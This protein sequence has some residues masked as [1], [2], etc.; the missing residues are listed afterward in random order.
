MQDLIKQE[1]FEIEVLDRLKSGRFLDK[2]VFTGGTMLRLCYGLN[3]YSVDLDFWIVKE[4][5]MSK[6]Y[7]DLIKYMTEFYTIKDSMNKFYTIVIEMRKPD[8]ARSLKI[9]IRKEKRKVKTEQTIAYSQYS[10][11]QVLLKAAALEDM[12]KSKIEAFL[13]R[14]EIRDIFD[15]EFLFKKGIPLNSE[16]EVLEKIIKGIDSLTKKDYSVKLGS[17]LSKEEREYYNKSNFRIIK[18]NISEIGTAPKG[19]VP[20][21]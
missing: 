11:T 19:T 20:I 10:N 15:V 12:M 4:I 3:R 2:L 17:L 8:F 7:K 1:Q 14:K 13:S 18:N 6:L 5:D 9:E 16:P 21:S